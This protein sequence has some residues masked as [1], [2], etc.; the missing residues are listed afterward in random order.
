MGRESI[1]GHSG[2]RSQR[3]EMNIATVTAPVVAL[4]MAESLMLSAVTLSVTA[5]VASTGHRECYVPET[6]LMLQKYYLGKIL[7]HLIDE[8]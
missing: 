2:G 6:T 8:M 3:S 4:S 1:G 7:K 5:I